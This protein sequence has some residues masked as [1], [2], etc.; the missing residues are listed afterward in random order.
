MWLFQPRCWTGAEVRRAEFRGKAVE[1]V[2]VRKGEAGDVLVIPKAATDLKACREEFFRV[3]ANPRIY[4]VP[5][6]G[7]RRRNNHTH[8]R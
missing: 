7:R 5:R 8:G 1:F 2:P 4:P 3:L 6:S